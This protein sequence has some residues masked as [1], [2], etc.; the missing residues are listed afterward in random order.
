[1]QKQIFVIIFCLTY[2][3]LYYTNPILIYEPIKCKISVIKS[4]EIIKMKWYGYFF[5]SLLVSMLIL[6]IGGRILSGRLKIS[7]GNLTIADIIAFSVVIICAV[8]II[9]HEYQTWISKN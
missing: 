4:T 6:F 2:I 3:A 9:V 8:L 1:M 5:I 7:S